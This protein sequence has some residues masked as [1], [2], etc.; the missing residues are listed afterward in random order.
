MRPLVCR[1]SQAR[2]RPPPGRSR[3]VG[4]RPRRRPNAVV[5]RSAFAGRRTSSV[6][7]SP[8][9]RGRWRRAR[10]KKESAAS[11]V[12]STRAE[13]RRRET[14]GPLSQE[15]PPAARPPGRRGPGCHPRFL[16]CGSGDGPRRA[17]SHCQERHYV[18]ATRAL[19]SALPAG[20]S[21]CSRS[22][23]RRLPPL[24]CR[25]QDPR[26]PI[27]VH[28]DRWL[29]REAESS[30]WAPGSGR[31]PRRLG[32]VPV[33]RR[34]APGLPRECRGSVVLE[35]RR[36]SSARPPPLSPGV[37][38]PPTISKSRLGLR[39]ES[40]GS[41]SRAGSPSAS[42]TAA[43]EEWDHTGMAPA[44]PAPLT[45]RGFSGD[46]VSTWA[47]SMGGTSVAVGRR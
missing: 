34:G 30:W 16:G 4:G 18:R 45:P 38:C 28:K 22:S 9:P 46:G 21:S 7:S 6:S 11:T 3:H 35:D 32:V 33:L 13:P 42:S 24:R 25:H 37:R 23:D 29:A 17:G 2:R 47:F 5:W 39:A 27:E 43:S 40:P 12:R 1:P 15:R 44:S 14:L 8:G 31:R 19:R 41:R 26:Y 10:S 20:G 36:A